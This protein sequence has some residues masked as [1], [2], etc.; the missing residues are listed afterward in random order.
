MKTATA[1]IE[2]EPKPSS[3]SR[4]SMAVSFVL[5]STQRRQA[6]VKHGIQESVRGIQ[7]DDGRKVRT[8]LDFASGYLVS[9]PTTASG[10]LQLALGFEVV[11]CDALW[12]NLQTA[13]VEVVS[14]QHIL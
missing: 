5:T 11:E 10:L 12:I 7:Y 1:G 8:N 6:S 14:R 4:R 3:L 13:E 9:S 2:T